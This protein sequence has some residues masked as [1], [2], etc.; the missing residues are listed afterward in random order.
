ML[1]IPNNQI[2]F[3]QLPTSTGQIAIQVNAIVSIRTAS[4]TTTS[5][6]VNHEDV[7]YTIEL[8][9]EDVM[10]LL[11]PDSKVPGAID[12]TY[13]RPRNHQKWK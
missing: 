1:P 2:L 12:G 6:R 4:K 5:I 9:Y 10:K 7:G 8:P 13:F 11:L 3:L